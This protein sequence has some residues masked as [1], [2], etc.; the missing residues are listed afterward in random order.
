MPP[1]PR[2]DERSEKRHRSG[3]ERARALVADD[4]AEVDALILEKMQSEVP[5]IP[6][7]A[8]HLIAAGGK[9]IRPMLTLLAA[10]LCGYHG[11]RHIGL[12]TCVEFIH[13]ATL[14]HDDVVDDSEL[15]R[16]SPSANA[17]FGNK[18]PVLVGDFLFSRAFQLMVADGS[19]EVLRILSEAS[20]IIAE[21]E[22]AQLVTANDTSSTEEDYLR[23]VRAKTA[24]LFRAACEIGAVVAGRSAMEAEA[25]ATYGE[26]LGIAF[27]LVD[28]ALDYAADERVLGKAVGDDFRDGKITLP[29]LLAFRDGSEEERAFWRRTLERLEQQ[30]GDLAQAMELLARHRAIERTLEQARR[31]GDTARRALAV[32]APSAHRE[33][34]LGL[35]DFCLER[36]H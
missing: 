32:F 22:V 11:R 10:R 13:T 1:L 2:T 4:L 23:V 30:P 16:G 33:A 17:I 24:A 14:L 28:D 29:V 35:V 6:Q 31:F 12:A 9:R 19:L 3:F 26:H 20:A 34:L 15:R 18:A 27:Q 8:R 5:L 25:L 36:D 7:L 21:G